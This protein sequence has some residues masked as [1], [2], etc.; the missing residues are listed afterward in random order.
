MLLTML[1]L[2][3]VILLLLLL[4]GSFSW[5]D[6]V[7][8]KNEIR[9]GVLWP[10]AFSLL[11]GIFLQLQDFLIVINRAAPDSSHKPQTRADCFEY[12][13]LF[14]F[15]NMYRCTVLDVTMGETHKLSRAKQALAL[16]WVK[17]V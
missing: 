16:G 15:Q 6:G 13:L 5:L 3:L 12:F 2:L 11:F 9:D 1:A 14:V 4:H 17:L 7:A 8:N 10:T